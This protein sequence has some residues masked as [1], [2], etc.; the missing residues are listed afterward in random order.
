MLGSKA[1]SLSSAFFMICFVKRRTFISRKSVSL[2][3]R[4]TRTL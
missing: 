1:F 4:V 3:R 2:A